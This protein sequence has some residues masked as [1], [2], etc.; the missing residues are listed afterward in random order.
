VE[1]RAFQTSTGTVVL[2]SDPAT[3]EGSGPI[4]FA[5]R[6]AMA[7]LQD[8]EWLSETVP[9]VV[10]THL[11]GFHSPFLRDTSIAAFIHAYDAAIAEMFGSRPVTVL[12]VSAGALV[13]A[14]LTSTQITGR[15]MIEPFFSTANLWAL[16]ELV[17]AALPTAN[18]A[19]RRWCWDVLG[20]S[21]SSVADRQYGCLLPKSGRRIAIVGDVPLLPRRPMWTLPSLTTDDDRRLLEASCV[22]VVVA[23]GGH[24]IPQSDKD[25]ILRALGRL[26]TRGV[27]QA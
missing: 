19:Y 22:E 16:V 4:V 25:A 27:D 13:A 10:Y 24:N 26:L 8:L 14:G 11:P 3:F 12:G 5:I 23:S 21:S 1:P 20:I 2:W 18:E 7:G 9:N 15:L 6:G 17:R